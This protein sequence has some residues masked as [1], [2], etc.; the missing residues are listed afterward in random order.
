MRIKKEIKRLGYFWSHAEP[1]RKVPG[2]LSISDGG[3]VQLEVLGQLQFTAPDN[4]LKQI[5]GVIEKGGAVTLTDCYEKETIV[6]L[7]SGIVRSTILVF[8]AFIGTQFLDSEEPLFR[9]LSFSVEGLNEWIGITGI[10][11]DTQPEEKGSQISYQQPED[12]LF[13]LENG[14]QLLIAFSWIPPR[15][16]PKSTEQP[17]NPRA[18][19]KTEAK[20][21]QKIYFK[22]VSDG[23]CE[24]D[25][26]VSVAYN[27][28]TLLCF[29]T[30]Q[31]VSL[32]SML[33][34]SEI[35]CGEIGQGKTEEVK[36]DIYYRSLPDGKYAAENSQSDTLFTFKE[37]QNDAKGAIN[38]WI[39]ANGQDTPT[40]GLYFCTQMV[41]QLHTEARFLTL[42]QAVEA[43]YRKRNGHKMT[44]H[45]KIENL[46]KPFVAI[47]GDRSTRENLICSIVVTR[48]Y[49]THYKPSLEQRAAKDE[50]LMTL[51]LKMELFL[52]LHFLK[53]IGFSEEKIISIVDRSKTL[54]WKSKQPPPI[55]D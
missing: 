16:F 3:F 20:I 53:L 33:A 51:C 1:G 22:L 50:D 28:T 29:A 42:V 7:P 17:E 5:V 49:L 35:F 39:K 26:F 43:Y 36:M 14:M 46:I 24:L 52:Q 12:V 21:T 32:D 34:T 41:P 40:F 44:L 19:Y 18:Y 31:V 37:I 23:A 8:T 54:R 27:I 45:E 47:I 2:T 30:N 4:Y 55:T 48:N 15:G 6:D 13:K 25:D 10:R 38:K 11:A 9:T